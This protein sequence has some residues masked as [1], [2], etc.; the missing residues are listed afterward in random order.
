MACKE[1][2]NN[3]SDLL[4]FPCLTKCNMWEWLSGTK[5]GFPSQEVLKGFKN[6]K[7]L[8]LA[9]EDA[10][11]SSDSSIKCQFTTTSMFSSNL[12]CRTM[13][14]VVQN[15]TFTKVDSF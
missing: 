11:Y 14:W 3:L 15:E 8:A 2:E 6:Y 9:L 10:F 12:M 1:A 13:Q 7:Y 4:F 5:R